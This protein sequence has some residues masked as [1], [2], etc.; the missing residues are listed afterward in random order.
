M[1]VYFFQGDDL[2]RQF[3]SKLNSMEAAVDK[4]LRSADHSSQIATRAK[5][6]QQKLFES[7]QQVIQF[8]YFFICVILL[9]I[10]RLMNV[11]R[12]N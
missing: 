2:S 9:Q 11:F 10:S 6:S 8:F 1:S 7:H 4:I 5:E 12:I 3:E